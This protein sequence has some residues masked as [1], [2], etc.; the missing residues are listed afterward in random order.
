MRDG[1]VAQGPKRLATKPDDLDRHGARKELI[2]TH[3]HNQEATGKLSMRMA[4]PHEAA[5]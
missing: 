4:S 3:V 5:A 2:S 1:K